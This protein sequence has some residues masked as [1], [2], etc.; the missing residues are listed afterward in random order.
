MW[1]S[2]GAGG[3]A[4]LYRHFGRQFG[5]FFTKLNILLHMIQ[6]LCSLVFAQRRWKQ[7]QRKTCTQMSIAA[8][9]LTVITWKRRRPTSIGKW[10][11]K[12]VHSL[13]GLFWV[14]KK[15]YQAMKS[16]GRIVNAYCKVKKVILKSLYIHIYKSTTIWYTE[17]SKT[18]ELSRGWRWEVDDETEIERIFRAMEL[19]SLIL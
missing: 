12:L 17:K 19:S 3:N 15:C 8:L 9:F 16:H 5:G 13:N 1:N 14:K 6:Q 2:F 11:N 10:I 18:F 7:D 4:K